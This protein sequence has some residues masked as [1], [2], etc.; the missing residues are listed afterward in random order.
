MP[1]PVEPSCSSSLSML[2]DYLV[3]HVFLAL[4]H[5][6]VVM[7]QTR[8]FTKCSERY[9][10]ALLS[11]FFVVEFLMMANR[12]CRILLSFLCASDISSLGCLVC[13]PFR[14]IMLIAC[15]SLSKHLLDRG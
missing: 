3:G 1:P 7:A 10:V 2:G 14:A 4:Y 5:A 15:S 11:P 8:S 12:P 6:R 9:L 13:F